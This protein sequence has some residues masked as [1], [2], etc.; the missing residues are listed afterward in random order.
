MISSFITPITF[1]AQNNLHTSF[2]LEY[3]EPSE[4][5][6]PYAQL[7]IESGIF[8]DAIADLEDFFVLPTPIKVVFASGIPGPQYFQGVI[9]MP[10]EFLHQNNLIL[11]ASGFSE[12]QQ[13]V[14]TTL[15]NLT[16]FVLYHEVGHAL[17]DVLDIPI[18]GKEEDAVDGFASVLSTIWELD[19]VAL[20]AADVFNAMSAT[21]GNNEIS[22]S[23]FWDTH[24]LNE[25]RM[26]NIFCLIYGSNPQKHPTLLEDIGMPV[27]QSD[28]CKY[29]FGRAY[30]NWGRVLSDFIRE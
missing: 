13:E 19:E 4:E 17:C 15:L 12:D 22:D 5:M 16:E 26:F 18:L 27:E 30:R 23:E 24:S 29:D 10:Y 14:I 20:S 11:G 1:L 7:V 6:L 2:I 21:Q 28:R 25:Q 3:H 9:N 8:D